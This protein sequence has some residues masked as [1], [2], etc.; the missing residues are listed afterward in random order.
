MKIDI[1]SDTH[2]DS[3]F[4]YPHTQSST[5]FPSK[6][7]VIGFWRKFKPKG[8]YLILQ[9]ILDTVLNKMFIFSNISKKPFIKR[10]FWS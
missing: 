2:F 9:E 10:L 1:L 7:A 4:G 5:F 3:W 8:D 6:D